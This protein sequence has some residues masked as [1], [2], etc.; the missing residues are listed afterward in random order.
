MSKSLTTMGVRDLI[1][2]FL[3][4]LPPDVPDEILMSLLKDNYQSMPDLIKKAKMVQSD[5]NLFIEYGF[6]ING[7]NG[8]YRLEMNDEEIVSE[9]LEYKLNQ[10]KGTYFSFT[11]SQKK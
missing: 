10:R 4:D 5:E 6:R 7:I 3:K 9:S 2:D 11:P 8:E 1:Q